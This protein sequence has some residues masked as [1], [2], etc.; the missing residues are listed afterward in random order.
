MRIHVI[1]RAK[2]R[3]TYYANGV[4]T[5]NPILFCGD[6]ESNPGPQT[7]APKCSI[8]DKTTRKNQQ[9]L[10]CEVC[11]SFTHVSCVKPAITLNRSH[12]PHRWTC[13]LCLHHHLP[14]RMDDLL[15]TSNNSNIDQ[16][17]DAHKN[18]LN[19]HPKQLKVMHLNMQSLVSTFNEF[20]LF[21]ENYDFDLL[22][23]SETWL[24]SNKH[25][26]DYVKLS[27][28]DLLYNNRESIKGGGVACYVKSHIKYKR[29][30]DIE[31]KF[32][33]L[34]HLWVEIP[35]R[36]KNCKILI[37]VIYRSNL[38]L[39][40]NQWMEDFEN[41]NTYIKCIWNHPVVIL[42]DMNI[43]LL[44]TANR[45][46]ILY[47]D[48]LTQHNLHQVITKPTRVTPNSS[49]LIDHILITDPKLVTHSDVLPCG[50]IS[51]HD[52]VYIILNVRKPRF[53][54]RFKYIRNEKNFDKIAFIN[55]VNTLPLSIVY[56][57][58]NPN[59]QI[60]I[61]NSLLLESIERSAPMKRVKI[62]RPAR[63]MDAD[64]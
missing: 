64:W 16:Y 25:L 6:V 1:K 3:V 59:E 9:R 14:F 42:G 41:L 10:L 54:P 50:S 63:S 44:D 26:L 51:D 38:I 52:A 45:D 57:V 28:F 20:S 12:I 56:S 34:E 53:T 29:R 15:D 61:F 4:A 30:K 2:G 7:H 60:E 18:N 21:C 8:C 22:C 35:G 40:L 39:P 62:T 47:M 48:T 23:L 24:R 13:Q 32:P 49:T 37:G 43:N 55:D 31:Q 5:F 33:N 27:S 58:D 36:N 19:H 17:E 11:Q 46:T